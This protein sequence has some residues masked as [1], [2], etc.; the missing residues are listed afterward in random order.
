[1]QITVEYMIMVPVMILQIFLFPY[2]AVM[3]MDNWNYSRQTLELQETAGKLGSTIQ[4]M[5]YTINRASVSTGSASMK[6]DIDIPRGIENHPYTVTLQNVPNLNSDYHIMNITLCFT[7]ST[8]STSTLVTLGDNVN[9]AN[10]LN[11]NSATA[12]LCLIAT[13]TSESVTLTLEDAA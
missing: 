1:M 8:V 7:D 2:V 9:W 6:I 13:K 4:Q 3:L 11:F 5:Y 12:E 10:N